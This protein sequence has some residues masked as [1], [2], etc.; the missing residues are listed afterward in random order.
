MK[1]R[2]P[3][4][5]DPGNFPI[6]QRS[7]F[8]TV[9]LPSDIATTIW[10]LKY[11]TIASCPLSCFEFNSLTPLKSDTDPLQVAAKK[12]IEDLKLLI[13][14]DS[15]ADTHFYQLLVQVIGHIEAT[16]QM[17]IKIFGKF[18]VSLPKKP[19]FSDPHPKKYS[20]LTS[21]KQA[22]IEI[23]GISPISYILLVGELKNK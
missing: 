3:L 7:W 9:R 11:P 6:I 22:I 8:I 12:F 21:A 1:I 10:P 20:G 4:T 5:S 19:R 14:E 2:V 17:S 15:L 18:F 23:I 13:S 16:K